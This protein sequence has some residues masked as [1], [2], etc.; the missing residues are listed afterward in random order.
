MNFW[1]TDFD[2]KTRSLTAIL[3]LVQR[4]LAAGITIYAPQHH[5]FQ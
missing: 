2:V 3:F 5:H 4:G 1:K